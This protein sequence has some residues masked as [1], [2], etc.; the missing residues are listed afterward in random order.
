MMR[1]PGH[2]S[3]APFPRRITRL[4]LLLAGRRRAGLLLAGRRL[5]GLLLAGLLLGSAGAARADPGPQEQHKTEAQAVEAFRRIMTLWREEVYFELY[6]QGTQSSKARITREEFAQRMVQLE[7]LPEG[8]IN[9]RFLKAEYRFRTQVYI[10][11][12]IPYR[13]KFNVGEPFA[14]D[15]TVLLLQEDGQW[16][17]DLVQLVRSPYVQ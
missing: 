10:Q 1:R 6:D 11:A 5:A 16:H 8:E 15:Q 14:K 3:S 17:L 2:M 9:P 12:R 4:T 7:W 13:N